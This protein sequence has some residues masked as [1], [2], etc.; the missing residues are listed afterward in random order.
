MPTDGNNNVPGDKVLDIEKQK[1][2]PGDPHGPELSAIKLIAEDHLAVIFSK[3][4]ADGSTATESYTNK[5][6]PI[7]PDVKKAFAALAPHLGTMCLWIRPSKETQRKV[8]DLEPATFDGIKI[9]ALSL[10]NGGIVITGRNF[11]PRDGAWININTPFES[12]NK[13]LSNYEFLV[14]LNLAV[15][16]LVAEATEWMAGT[17]RAP[18]VVQSEL[19]YEEAPDQT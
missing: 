10:K 18:I 2:H 7:H 14:D 9:S 11:R 17:K 5:E 13:E 1:S 15:D 19:E 12:L 4:E 3:L 16:N 6:R 8:E